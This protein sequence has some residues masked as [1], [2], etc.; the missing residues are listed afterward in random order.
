MSASEI[1]CLVGLV[2]AEHALDVNVVNV[3]YSKNQI[4]KMKE[5]LP[6]A[7]CAVVRLGVKEGYGKP[8]S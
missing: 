6:E 5:L 4:I 2:C 3:R 1:Y 8:V 7:K